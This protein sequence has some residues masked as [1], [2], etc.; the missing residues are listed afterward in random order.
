MSIR[1]EI[2]DEDVRAAMQEIEG[3]LDISLGDFRELYG[4]ALRL[5]E[6]RLLSSTPIVDIMTTEVVT[7]LANTPF[8]EVIAAM[9]AK[10]ISG[11]PVVD[12]DSK[13]IGVVSEKDIFA[14]LDDSREPSF[15]RILGGCLECNKCLLRSLRGVRAADIMTAPPLTVTSMD[16]ARIALELMRRS[17][18]NRLPVVDTGGKLCGI[19]TRS[20][21][22]QATLV[23][24]EA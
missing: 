5:A 4:H 3:Y 7:V 20:D 2:T 24:T 21:L 16:S 8:E 1:L 18:V 22:L 13:V 23:Q 11:M 10:P 19:V 6:K 12:A 14:R 17:E 9:A 15:W